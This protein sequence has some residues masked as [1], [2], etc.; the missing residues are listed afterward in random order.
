MNLEETYWAR[1]DEETG[2]LKLFT[3]KGYNWPDRSTAA[4]LEI[5]NVLIRPIKSEC[6]I[7]E[8]Y[9]RDFFPNERWQQAGIVLLDCLQ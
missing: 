1:R 8:A 6:F 3:L 4:S 9:L 7:A 5:K 2:I